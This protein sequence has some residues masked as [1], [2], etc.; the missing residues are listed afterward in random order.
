MLLSLIKI[1]LTWWCSC[2]AFPLAFSASSLNA[3][4]VPLFNS[5]P[6][7]KRLI[8]M[9]FGAATFIVLHQHSGEQF[10]FFSSNSLLCF[11]ANYS[12]FV[13]GT[14]LRLLGPA[15]RTSHIICFSWVFLWNTSVYLVKP[16]CTH[17]NILCL[18]NLELICAVMWFLN[19]WNRRITC[20]EI[21]LLTAFLRTAHP[22]NFSLDT[23][24]PWILQIQMW[25]CLD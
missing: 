9:Q 13:V 17:I 8:Q 19:V 18:S 21:L 25:N 7:Q 16:R 23:A 22:N 24:L 6:Y 11:S 12:Y 20:L 1:S 2:V 14:V 15:I 3:K 4:F 5:Q 10:G